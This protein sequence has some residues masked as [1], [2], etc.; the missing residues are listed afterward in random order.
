MTDVSEYFKHQMDPIK[1]NGDHPFMHHRMQV[2]KLSMKL[3]PVKLAF[4]VFIPTQPDIDPER[5]TRFAER[6]I[7]EG[8]EKYPY[9]IAIHND[10][11][12]YLMDHHRVLAQQAA[13]L[14]KARVK[15]VEIKTLKHGRKK[16]Y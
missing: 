5:V 15:V 16:R 1:A 8:W 7:S 3:F 4:D 12:Y 11:K 13:G 9:P 10:D 14:D 2:K 6:L